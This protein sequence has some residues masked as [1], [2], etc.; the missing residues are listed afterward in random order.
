MAVS[1]DFLQTW[2][3]TCWWTGLLLNTK[4]QT[5]NLVSAHKEHQATP[6]PSLFCDTF[7]LLQ[8]RKKWWCSLLF[9][10][11][12]LPSTV[13][14]ERN[15]GET[16]K[17]LRLHNNWEISSKPCTQDA[18]TFLLMVTK[19]PRRLRPTKAW[20]R[21]RCPL[22]P[23]LY[24]LYTNDIDRFLT[25][26]RGAATALDSVPY[27]SRPYWSRSGPSL[28]LCWWHC[29]HFK[30]SWMSTG[31]AKQIPQLHTFQGAQAQHWQ[32]KS[33]GLHQQGYFCDSHFHVRWHTSRT[34]HSFQIPCLVSL[35]LVMEVCTQQ[36]RRWQ[37]T[38]G[39]P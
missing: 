21:A 29:S 17:K 23:L 37:T 14:Q 1:T 15:F 28:W 8:K 12:L 36:L 9:W 31:P 33:H 5:P 35:S 11:S 34:G 39:S 20:N 26:Q 13:F 18:S 25:V 22:S 10:T 3:V 19:L 27:W 38:W 30:H 7:S 6:N 2:S 24:S 16:C 4:Y 32:N